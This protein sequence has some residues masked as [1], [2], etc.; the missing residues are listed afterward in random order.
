M[1]SITPKLSLLV[2]ILLSNAAFAQDLTGTFG[3]GVFNSAKNSLSE[4]KLGLL[5]L[6]L[7]VNPI[8]NYYT[9][10]GGW[11][12]KRADLGRE[13]STLLGT[14]L[15]ARVD[16]SSGVYLGAR[17][18]I[19]VINNPDTMLGGPFQFSEELSAGIYDKNST[20]MGFGLKHISSA[21]LYKVNMGRDF[22]TFSVAFPIGTDK[23]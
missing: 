23:K 15:G 13:G 14:G 19:N 2:A 9:E 1:Y 21:G 20:R 10:F 11:I 12:D 18:G 4:T 16:A 5:T 6:T 22:L 8:L 3:I 17:M 7:P